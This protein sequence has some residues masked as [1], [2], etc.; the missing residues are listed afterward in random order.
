MVKLPHFAPKSVW[1][2]APTVLLILTV[3]AL[4]LLPTLVRNGLESFLMTQGVKNITYRAIDVDIFNREL[5]F[6]ELHLQS[7]GAADLYLQQASLKLSLIPLWNNTLKIGSIRIQ[8]SEIN[9]GLNADGVWNLGG[10]KLPL[11]ADTDKKIEQPEW[12]VQVNNIELKNTKLNIVTPDLKGAIDVAEAVFNTGRRAMKG[13]SRQ[14]LTW[15]Y[16]INT[17]LDILWPM[18]K[19]AM[20]ANLA[21]SGALPKSENF[22]AATVLNANAQL[23]SLVFT[24]NKLNLDIF[25]ASTINFSD[26]KVAGNVLTINETV[27]NDARIG[28]PSKGK[29]ALAPFALLGQTRIQALQW[30]PDKRLHIDS[31][32]LKS[33][34]VNAQRLKSGQWKTATK[35]EQRATKRNKTKTKTGKHNQPLH[36]LIKAIELDSPAQIHINDHTV[37]P[38]VKTNI[39]LNKKSRLGL[40]DNSQPSNKSPLIL[41]GKIDKYGSF[42]ITGDLQLFAPQTT[43]NIQAI[44]NRLELP[45]LSPYA[46]P[47]MGY[48]ITHG[49]LDMKSRFD[50]ANGKIKGTSKL[51]F[52]K[53]KIEPVNQ[54]TIDKF[55]ARLTLPLET[56]ILLLEE[57]NKIRLN[58]PVSGSTGDPDFSFTDVLNQAVISGLRS[59]SLSYLKYYFQPYGAL[60]TII[61]LGEKVFKIRLEPIVFTAGGSTLDQKSRDYLGQVSRLMKDKKKLALNLCGKVVPADEVTD[62]EQANALARSRSENARNYLAEDLKIE[63]KR[64]YICQPEPDARQDA[65]PRVELEF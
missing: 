26:I 5:R 36:V 15:R 48:Q 10:L 3:V 39:L 31:I 40:V 11:Q 47:K 56:I 21:S 59:A 33:A 13:G 57:K 14:Q 30:A 51:T 27:I 37:S 62:P 61:Q 45:T 6:K 29:K 7:P 52:E 4:S 63:P 34:K 43:Y 18:K 64:L 41:T 58:V 49:H 25:R 8:G 46:V 1:F 28:D 38:A 65:Q 2:W 17:H 22:Q 42:E 24:D 16:K 32:V 23:R 50:A 54:A 44:I 12:D 60:V 53:L 19:L 55:T 35:L 20:Q 9:A